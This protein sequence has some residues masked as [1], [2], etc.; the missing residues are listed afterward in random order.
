MRT[1]RHCSVMRITPCP[2]YTESEYPEQFTAFIQRESAKWEKVI[3]AAGIKA[4]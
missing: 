4:E 2:L 3:K 1:E